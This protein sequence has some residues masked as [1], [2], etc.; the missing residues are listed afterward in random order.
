MK[1]KTIQSVALYARVSTLDKGQDPE[2]QLRELRAHAAAQNLTVFAEYL[3]HGV[4]GSKASRPALDRMMEDARLSK[5]DAV[6]VWKLD[7]F[8]RSLKHMI[9]SLDVLAKTGVGFISLRD[10]LD[11]STAAGRAMFQMIGVFAEFEREMTRERV[12]AGLVNARAKGKILGRKK[13][14]GVDVDLI[15][16][17][18]SEGKSWRAIQK[19][20]GIPQATLRGR[21]AQG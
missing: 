5:F 17:L 10:N 16:M 3:D 20:T 11:F 2:M 4:S 6:L 7:R 18:R 14:A 1:T 12:R 19:Q 9:I 21:C 15:R 13:R 8:S